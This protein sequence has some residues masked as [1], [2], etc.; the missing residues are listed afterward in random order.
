MLR[1]RDRV[2]AGFA[3]RFPMPPMAYL[4]DLHYT[5]ADEEQVEWEQPISP[6]FLTTQG[7]VPGG[8]LAVLADC[9]LGSAIS[10]NLAPRTPFST[11][12]LALNFLRAVQPDSGPLRARARQIHANERLALS[13][14]LI[15]EPGRRT[16]GPGDIALRAGVTDPDRDR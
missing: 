13:E 15:E 2:R 6:W 7:V 10:A 11:S 8:F 5:A 16:G 3:G 4:A 14:C 1:G 9:A 12:E